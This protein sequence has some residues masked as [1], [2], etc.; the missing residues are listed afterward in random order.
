MLLLIGLGQDID[1][2]RPTLIPDNTDGLG[3]HLTQFI[4]V[5]DRAKTSDAKRPRESGKVGLGLLQTNPN[6]LVLDRSPAGAGDNFLMPLVVVVGT[7]V[8][9][10]VENRNL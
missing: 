4:R 2:S 8:E 10:H 9:H 6:A 5:A 7:V 1:Q 3:Q